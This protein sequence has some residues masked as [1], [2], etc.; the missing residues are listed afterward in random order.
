[1]DSTNLKEDELKK[2]KTLIYNGVETKPI[3]II[4]KEGSLL[5]FVIGYHPKGRSLALHKHSI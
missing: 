5:V 4:Q 1:M 3:F 2:N